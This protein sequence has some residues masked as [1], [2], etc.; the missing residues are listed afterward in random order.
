[1]TTRSAVV[2]A[3]GLALPSAATAQEPQATRE[4]V[5]PE[6]VASATVQRSVRPDLATITLRFSRTGAT[7]TDAG[8]NVALLADSVRGA[9]AALGIPR[10]STPTASQWW[11][12]R[13]RMEP[14][15]VPGPY[16]PRTG[17]RAQDTTYQAN[18]SMEVRIGDLSKVGKVIDAILARG[19]T[20]ISEPRFSASN[21]R[22][23]ELD[24][25]AE[26]TR[27]ARARAEAIA[28][29]GGG[30]LGRTRLLSTERAGDPFAT[31]IR[32]TPAS[33]SAAADRVETVVVGPAI[34][35]VARVY[36]RWE[37]VERP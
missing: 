2:L 27:A 5:P 12:P 8:R 22:Q 17:M 33:E 15:V 35:V 36:G 4:S 11:W 7:P 34:R 18:E 14:R 6:V 30:R 29:A 13:T 26:A 24:A 19:I 21:T 9:L 3:C 1:M 28:A 16:N 37:L 10:D 23:A 25:V 20:D 32:L 31:G